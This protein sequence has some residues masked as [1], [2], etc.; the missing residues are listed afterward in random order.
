MIVRVFVATSVLLRRYYAFV[1]PILNYCSPVWGSAAECQ[2]QLLERLVYSVARLCADH[3]F[4]SLC[5]R[6][7][8]AGLC[9]LY[10]DNSNSN[11]CL[12]SELPSASTR[13]RH[14]RPAAAA[15]PLEFKVSRCRT[16]Q[17]QGVSWR[18]R[19]ECGMTFPTLCLIPE[20]WMGSSLQSTI[21]CFPEF[22][23]SFSF[24][25]R[26]CLWGCESNI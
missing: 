11:H 22:C 6:H 24:P 19:F 7:H 21:C 9:M 3:C 25:W 13:L 12:F 2:L 1:L 15:H 14:T 8:V 17:L 20:V 5:H 26:R 10:K 23:F 4:L 18:P 16:S